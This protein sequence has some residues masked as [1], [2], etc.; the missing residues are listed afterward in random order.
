MFRKDLFKGA[1]SAMVVPP[2][3]GTEAMALP[4]A[5]NRVAVPQPSSRGR[6][7]NGCLGVVG[8]RSTL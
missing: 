1:P 5:G 6:I 3:V 7:A 2:I 4:P 8:R